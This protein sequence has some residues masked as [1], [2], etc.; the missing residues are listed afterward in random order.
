MHYCAMRLAFCRQLL[1]RV[2]YG[3]LHNGGRVRNVLEV[4][5]LDTKKPSPD[6]VSSEG[7]G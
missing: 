2:G 6:V 1:S 3:L 4:R 5:N 7:S